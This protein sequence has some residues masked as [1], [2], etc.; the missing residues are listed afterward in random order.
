MTVP[1]C[2]Y[3][4]LLLLPPLEFLFFNETHLY[5]LAGDLT[6]STFDL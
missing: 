4:F 3:L 6:S 5:Q 2:A 1:L